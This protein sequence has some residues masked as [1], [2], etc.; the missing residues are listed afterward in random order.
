MKSKIFKVIVAAVAIYFTAGAAAGW[1][2]GLSGA[3]GAAAGTAAGAATT[4]A[5]GT[6]AAAGTTAAA[7]TAA[8]VGTAAAAGT[9]AA[10]ST[11]IMATL[12]AN[13]GLI[14]A[15]ATAANGIMQ[16]Q[17]A[18]K[19]AK[20][21]DRQLT[22]N[23]KTQLN[24]LDDTR[25]LLERTGYYSKEQQGVVNDANGNAV[26]QNNADAQRERVAAQ[27]EKPQKFFNSG[28]NSWE[29]VSQ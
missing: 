24:I 29:E 15:G 8:T 6:A 26:Y 12:Q 9:T 25:S 28:S 19:D 13:A 5:A 2:G 20:E 14:A 10:A 18:R 3:G 11:G 7:T 17:A 27:P 21:Y 22:E 16:Q 1:V 4:A 23:N